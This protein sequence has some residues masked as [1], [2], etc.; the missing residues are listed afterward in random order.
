MIIYDAFGFK[1]KVKENNPKFIA[2]E[3]KRA[4][5]YAKKLSKDANPYLMLIHIYQN[6]LPPILLLFL[7]MLMVTMATSIN[8][9]C[10][11]MSSQI[12]FI[13]S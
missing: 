7:I 11:L 2:T 10:Y 12:I 5:T 1:P 3:I 4:K 13:I 8:L 6:L 9:A